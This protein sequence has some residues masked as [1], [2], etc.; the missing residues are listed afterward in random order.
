[1]TEAGPLPLILSRTTAQLL[2][3]RAQRIMTPW[4]TITLF[5]EIYRLKYMD[6]YGSYTLLLKQIVM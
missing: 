6:L 5:K 1:M 2:N 3:T 4:E